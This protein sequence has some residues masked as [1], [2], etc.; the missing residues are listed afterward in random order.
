MKYWDANAER[1]LQVLERFSFLRPVVLVTD[2]Y[3][4]IF[5]KAIP[6]VA[7]FDLSV[8]PAIFILDLIAKATVAV[9]AELP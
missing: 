6:P 7:G 9:G 5:R 1:F 2:P 3:L 4:N 8:I